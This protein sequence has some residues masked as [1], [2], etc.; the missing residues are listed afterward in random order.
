MHDKYAYM[1]DDPS[2]RAALDRTATGIGFEVTG[3][4]IYGR[5]VLFTAPTINLEVFIFVS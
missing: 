1:F 2:K 5:V 4:D 3:S